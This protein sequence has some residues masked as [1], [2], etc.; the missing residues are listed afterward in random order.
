MERVLYEV[1]KVIVGQDHLLERMVVALLARGHI[2]VEGVPG[3][4]KTMAVKTLSRA[5]GGEFQRIQFT[6]DLLPADLIGTRIYNQRTGEFNTAKGPVFTNLLLAFMSLG[7][8]VGIAALG[9]V[10]ARAVVERRHQIGV[11]R[12]I[13]Y[14]RGMVQLSFL[15]ESSFIAL[16]GIV[17][18]LGLGLLTSI[19]V[20]SSISYEESDYRLIVPWVQVI[21]IAVA[22]YLLSLLTTFLPARR[23]GHI[24]PAEA[25]RYE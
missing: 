4:A 17:M 18:G 5:I 6:P 20:V 22:A 14:S 13:G 23:A 3:L 10:S 2:L 1:K 9:V 7:L 16:L 19:N 25:L 15:L 11:L 12:A 24:A 21:G 8:V